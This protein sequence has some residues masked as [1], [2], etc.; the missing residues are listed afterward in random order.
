MGS[1]T[2]LYVVIKS[3]IKLSAL[4]NLDGASLV[5]VASTLN[6]WLQ[7]ENI[8]ATFV[9]HTIFSLLV[10][11]TKYLQ[12]YGLNILDGVKSLEKSVE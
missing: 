8:V 1:E 5:L 11:T 6:F 3:L 12:N 9:L 4:R 2:Q 10:P 7:Y